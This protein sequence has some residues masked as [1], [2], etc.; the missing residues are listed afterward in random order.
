MSSGREIP[1]THVG[2]LKAVILNMVLDQSVS[3][4]WESVRNGGPGTPGGPPESD[5]GV[6]PGKVCCKGPSQRFQYSSNMRSRA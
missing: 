3:I 5:K 2:A 1:S 4:T 6:G